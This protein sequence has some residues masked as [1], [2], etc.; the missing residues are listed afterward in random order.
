[1]RSIGQS[2][3]LFIQKMFS[4]LFRKI[5]GKKSKKELKD[6]VFFDKIFNNYQNTTKIFEKLIKKS[7]LEFYSI[8]EKCK[9]LL[10]TNYKLGLQHLE[11]GNFSDAKIRFTIIIKF[12]PEFQEAYYQK[13]YIL[14][15]ENKPHKAKEVIDKLILKNPDKLDQKF[16]SLIEQ[17]ESSLQSPQN[18]E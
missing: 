5:T 8:R 9:D 3:I 1:M 4:Y 7:I 10:N 12:W 15:L 11:K 18:N 13:A 14:M 2:R 6:E 17:I 16:T